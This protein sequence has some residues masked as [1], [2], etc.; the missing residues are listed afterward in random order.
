ME[1]LN[2][3]ILKLYKI[4]RINVN[5]GGIDFVMKFLGCFF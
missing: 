1:N 5:D 4:G 3:E 2:I